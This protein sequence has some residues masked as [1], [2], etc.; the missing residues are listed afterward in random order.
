MIMKGRAP[1]RLPWAGL[2]AL[3]VVAMATLPAW[4]TGNTQQPAPTPQVAQK[5]TPT[6]APAPA[7]T[8]VK[9]TPEPQPVPAVVSSRRVTPAPTATTHVAAPVEQHVTV[10][11][12]QAPPR[13]VQRSTTP[14]P[15]RAQEGFPV[16]ADPQHRSSFTFFAAPTALTDEGKK[17]VE[18]F[19]AQREAIQK[20]ADGKVESERQAAIKQLQALQEEYA[21][22][23]KLDE[24]VA[25]RDYL[26]AGGPS[27]AKY[28]WVIRRIP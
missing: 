26:R 6:P 3:A 17:L 5:P 21:K 10:T 14:R 9:P 27:D 19:A 8:Q 4:A 16:W 7:T 22:A 1:L 28:S 25:I 2:I 24:A 11:H 23:G 13:V 18:K 12:A 15:S 20:E